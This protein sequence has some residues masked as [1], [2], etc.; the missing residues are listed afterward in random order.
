ML[1]IGCVGADKYADTLR[2]ANDKAGLHVEYRID[3]KQPT[4]RCGVIITGHNR[5]MCTHLAAANEYKLEHL[6]SEKVWSQVQSA[7]VYYVGG[8]HLTVCPP[9]AMA[10]AKEAA[11]EKKIFALGIGAPFIASFFKDPLAET[12]PY[13][14]YFFG[15]ETEVT[16][17]AEAH[18]KD[19]KDVKEIARMMAELP[20]ENKQRKRTV[21]VTQGTEPTVVAI[22]GES[23]VHEYPVHEIDAKEIED[24]NGA[25]CVFACK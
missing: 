13:W 6:Q 11:K 14:D 15:N 2:E 4:G 7:S 10:L 20:K 12:A 3:D 21:V 5:S 17:W 16:A 19:T 24:T 25:G 23:K 8:Y 22:Q 1:Y 18:G 9:A